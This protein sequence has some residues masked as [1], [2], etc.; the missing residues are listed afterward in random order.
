MGRGLCFV[1]NVVAFIDLLAI[2]L[3]G[4]ASPGDRT[5]D[6]RDDNRRPPD[7][8]F[9]ISPHLNGDPGNRPG[10]GVKGRAMGHLVMLRACQR[11]SNILAACSAASSVFFAT[12]D[13][14]IRTS[15]KDPPHTACEY[16]TLY[17][18]CSWAKSQPIPSTSVYSSSS[19]PKLP[20]DSDSG[21]SN[22][23]GKSHSFKLGSSH[24]TQG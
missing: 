15:F 12:L 1:T 6:M 21:K 9:P 22:V 24:L 14:A 18:Q 16:S 11:K 4:C 13:D 10:K 5:L 19:P 7:D 3:G 20:K 23:S 8:R 17:V 2:D